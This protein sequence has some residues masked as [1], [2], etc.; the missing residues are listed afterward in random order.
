MEII[1]GLVGVLSA[2]KKSS[3]V[4]I[5]GIVLFIVN[6]WEFFTYDQNITQIV[7]H[8]LTLIVPYYYLHNAYR[9]IRS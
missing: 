9:N 4:L 1:T 3:L 7:I 2:N 6:L 5:L 8:A